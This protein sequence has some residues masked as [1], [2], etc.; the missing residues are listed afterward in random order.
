MRNY[1]PFVS[2]NITDSHDILKNSKEN[3]TTRPCT[4]SEKDADPLRIQLESA[5]KRSNR[6]AFDLTLPVSS[7]DSLAPIGSGYH[8]V[9]RVAEPALIQGGAQCQ[10]WFGKSI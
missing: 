1:L 2:T 7:I 4:P 8:Q 5:W 10:L 3:R 9:F 6:Q